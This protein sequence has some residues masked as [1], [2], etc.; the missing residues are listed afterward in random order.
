MICGFFHYVS[1]AWWNLTEQLFLSFPC[2]K[3]L[4][5]KRQI[6][7]HVISKYL[8][9]QVHLYNCCNKWYQ[10]WQIGQ[11]AN[12]EFK[13]SHPFDSLGIDDD[14]LSW[15]VYNFSLFRSVLLRSRYKKNEHFQ[16]WKDKW[17]T[18]FCNW[19][20]CQVWLIIPDFQD[21]LQDF[22]Q[23]CPRKVGIEQIEEN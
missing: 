22:E 1:L 3:W 8:F 12:N 14:S 18:Q 13:F 5:L 6:L 11:M 23:K 15:V 4:V 9:F 21:V 2:K 17:V 19:I 10:L 16:H 7:C 20:S